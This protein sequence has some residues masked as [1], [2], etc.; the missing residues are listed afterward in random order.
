MNDKHVPPLQLP[1]R[2]R[3]LHI[4]L[5]KTGTTGLQNAA[6]ALRPQLLEH[7]VRYPGT[8][9]NHRREVS[10]FMGRGWGWGAK[11][12]LENW[13]RL[14]AEVEADTTNKIWLGHEFASE[15]SEETV[16]RFREVL[17]ERTHVVVTLRHYGSILASSWQQYMKMGDVVDFESWLEA[18]LA[19]PPNRKVT[20]T[21][22][23]RNDQGLVVSRWAEV[24]GPENVTAVVIDKKTPNLLTDAFEELLG[25]PQAF[26]QSA[27]L[28]SF[29]S[30]RGMSVEEAELLRAVN[31]EF[32]RRK[33][34]WTSYE[35]WIRNG[36][37][38]RMMRERTPGD[39]DTSFEL[40]TWAA[41]VATERGNRY[42]DEIEATGVRIVGDTDALRAPAAGTDAPTFT[43]D[44]VPLDAAREGMLGAIDASIKSQR[45]LE[46]AKKALAAAEASRDD[47]VRGTIDGM[48]AS[49]LA[50][51]LARRVR[52]RA[53]RAIRHR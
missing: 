31:A 19:D 41:K 22:H 25:L 48:P 30:N 10:S 8:T 1:E 4:G 7:G 51:E 26:L 40:P 29:S 47:L 3:L 38:E 24:F 52:A 18:V 32:R 12:T 39:H 37:A 36:A 15:G 9:F 50:R 13:T 11:P 27:E 2:A 44:S 21:F 43:V 34:G 14:M 33:L 28:D 49:L 6:A 35:R 42:V 5:P 23:T 53:D 20:K 16:R 45:Q 17:G 46:K